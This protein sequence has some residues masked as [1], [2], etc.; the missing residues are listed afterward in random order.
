MKHKENF[1]ILVEVVPPRHG[2]PAGL[3]DKLGSLGHL[4]ISAFNVAS[5]PVAKPHLSAL[6]LAGLIQERTGI[7]SLPHVTTRDHNRLS[8][9]SL[10]WGAQ[11]RGIEEVL[12]T[13]GDYP[14]PEKSSDFTPAGDLT[15]YQ[16]LSLAGQEGLQAGV[17]LN[18]PEDPEAFQHQLDR[19]EKKVRLGAQ[20]VITQPL[21]ESS[22]AESLL[23]AAERIAVPIYPGVLPLHSLEHARFMDQQVRGI[24]IPA[25]LLEVMERSPDPVEAGIENARDMIRFLREHFPGMCLMPPFQRYQL[26]EKLL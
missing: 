5:N 21:Y 2:N 10:L 7:P 16:L 12:I 23:R 4:P 14:S 1:Q 18:L 24:D 26:V 13:T 25:K 15:V 6:V 17:V 9:I 3:L 22:R 19:L 8:L 11:A 20:F